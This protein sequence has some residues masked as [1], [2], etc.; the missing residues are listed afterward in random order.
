MNRSKQTILNV[1]CSIAVLLMN[2]AITFFLS[3]FIVEHIGVEAN[4][5]V[6]LANNCVTYAQLIVL[7]LNSMAARFITIAYA[8]GDLDKARRYYNSVF[9]GNLI[10]VAV[11][12]VPAI[13]CIVFLE[14]L[15]AVPEDI[16]LDVKLMFGF[17]FLNFFLT[18][19]APNWDCGPF[20]TNRL[21]KSYVPQAIA[22]LTRCIVLIGLFSILLP[23]VW[24][25]GLAATVMT[26]IVLAC[27]CYYT[28]KLTPE[29]RVSLRKGSREC[30]WEMIKELVGSGAWNSVSRVGDML[31]HG[32]D[33]VV[34]NVLVGPVAMGLLALS[35]MLPN[36]VQQLS[37][38]VCNAFMP[39]LTIDFAAG[40]TSNLVKNIK[41]SMKL[42][43]TVMIPAVAAVIVFG[44]AFFSLWV[45]T[46]DARLL[47]V[48]A[49]LDVAGY[50]FMSGTQIC[51]NVFTVTNKVKQNAIALL[52]SGAVALV[53]T[54]AVIGATDLGVLAIPAISTL[55]SLVRNMAFTVP[56]SAKYLGLRKRTFFPFVCMNAASTVAFALVGFAVRWFVPCDTWPVLVACAAVFLL[57]AF[58]V[59]ALIALD[60][61]ER[62]MLFER[63][64]RKA[65]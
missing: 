39:E 41:R 4:G 7:A 43:S 28:H 13:A 15:F 59:S 25:V 64:T 21:D 17:V 32:L 1:S 2:V 55:V 10:I 8:S 42:T 19:A 40:K 53:A 44:D 65:S 37:G 35:K 52:V 24:Y 46:E 61:D 18:T 63:I 54:I 3:P 31:L 47:Y 56:V 27:G 6:T 5:F 12:I 30:S 20:V 36:L 9:W 29:L 34:A 33:L 14:L 45:P 57:A 23:R 62:R 60:G 49:V 51:F 22:S 11:L 38:S 26:V 58:L 16:L 50:A 48:L